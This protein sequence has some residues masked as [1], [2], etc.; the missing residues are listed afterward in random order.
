M[1]GVGSV[2]G[3]GDAGTTSDLPESAAHGSSLAEVTADA[4]VVKCMGR[5]YKATGAGG[6]V[7][8]T[9]ATDITRPSLLGT[10]HA[11]GDG[12]DWKITTVRGEH[13]LTTSDLLTAVAALGEAHRRGLGIRRHGAAT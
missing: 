5:T 10:A 3:L 9:D 1:R 13:V 12:R 8:V 2:G 6:E 7:F 4:T 11:A